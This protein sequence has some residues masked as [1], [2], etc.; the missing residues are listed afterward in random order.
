MRASPAVPAA[1]DRNERRTEA[2]AGTPASRLGAVSAHRLDRPRRWFGRRPGAHGQTPALGRRAVLA[3]SLARRL[4]L[5]WTTTSSRTRGPGAIATSDCRV[6]AAL[7]A[8]SRVPPTQER[9]SR[10]SRRLLG[11][12]RGRGVVICVG[13]SGGGSAGGFPR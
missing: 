7:P 11:R 13:V 4:L 8:V 9:R 5:N 10:P 1:D 3:H 12:E 6:G 2:Q